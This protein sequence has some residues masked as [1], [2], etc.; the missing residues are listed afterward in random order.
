LHSAAQI[1][2]RV[3]TGLKRTGLDRQLGQP[4]TAVPFLVTG[5][6]RKNMCGALLQAPDMEKPL[7]KIVSRRGKQSKDDNDK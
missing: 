3:T 1:N 4:L 2:F 5:S 6:C 7:T